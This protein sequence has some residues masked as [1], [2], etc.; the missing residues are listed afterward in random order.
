MCGQ[1]SQQHAIA[2]LRLPY[3]TEMGVGYYY[4]Y[5]KR[6]YLP[7]FLLTGGENLHFGR[8]YLASPPLQGSSSCSAEPRPRRFRWVHPTHCP[9]WSLALVPTQDTRPRCWTSGLYEVGKEN[10]ECEGEM[11]RKDKRVEWEK[12]TPIMICKCGK[13]VLV[14]S[15]VLLWFRRYQ[16][17]LNF[18]VDSFLKHQF[19][20]SS[21][22]KIS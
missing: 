7:L 22:L 13:Y 4:M 11:A 6:R 14:A 8:R 2:L 18:K 9:S 3:A 21:K 17:C 1:K 20:S 16:S 15:I 19:S 5:T 10:K 12:M